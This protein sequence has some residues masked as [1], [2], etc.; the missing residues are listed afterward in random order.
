MNKLLRLEIWDT[1]G[2]ERFRN[3]ASIYYRN[4]GCV[5][6]TFDITSRSS[7]E[8]CGFWVK[9]LEEKGSPYSLKYLIGNKLDLCMEREVNTEVSLNKIFFFFFKSGKRRRRDLQEKME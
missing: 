7:F 1:A 2:Q 9:E 6:V 4:A 8:E 5:I 3:I